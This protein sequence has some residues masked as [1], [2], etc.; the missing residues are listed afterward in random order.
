VE[1][2]A[3]AADYSV[4]TF[5][6]LFPRKEDVIFFDLQERLGAMLE[7]FARGRSRVGVGHGAKD[8]H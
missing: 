8:V 4:S 6:R 7:D 5:F 3:N 2:I 1:Q